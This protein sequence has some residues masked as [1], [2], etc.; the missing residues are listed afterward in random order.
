MKIKGTFETQPPF[1][2]HGTLIRTETQTFQHYCLKKKNTNICLTFTMT[3]PKF[4]IIFN[5]RIIN[6]NEMFSSFLIDSLL[7]NRL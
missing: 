3:L 5:L 7:Q 2:L 6:P 4:G 1:F